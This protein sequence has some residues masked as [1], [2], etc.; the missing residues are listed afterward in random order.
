MAVTVAAV[1][2]VVVAVVVVAV[3]VAVVVVIIVF[4]NAVDCIWKNSLG[5]ERDKLFGKMWWEWAAARLSFGKILLL[6]SIP[7]NK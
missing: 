2:A 6:L 7:E 4:I 5:E 3:V 1:V